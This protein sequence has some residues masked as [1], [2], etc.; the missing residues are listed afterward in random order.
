MVAVGE[1][2]HIMP[3]DVEVRNPLVPRD[4]ETESVLPI[5]VMSFRWSQ[6][7]GVMTERAETITDRK[8]FIEVQ[9]APVGI[10]KVVLFAVAALVNNRAPR[11][12]G[13][14]VAEAINGFVAASVEGAFV[15][16]PRIHANK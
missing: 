8:S 6:N 2:T 12:S 16:S 1:Q 10:L 3:I 15:C 13:N 7:M 9:N 5:G 14:E 4:T 11:A